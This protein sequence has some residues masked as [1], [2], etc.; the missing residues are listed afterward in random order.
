MKKIILCI[1]GLLLQSG[2]ASEYPWS[3]YPYMRGSLSGFPD[4]TDLFVD[5]LVNPKE[6]DSLYGPV[7][8]WKNK[9]DDSYIQ[10]TNSLSSLSKAISQIISDMPE[11]HRK[12]AIKNAIGNYCRSAK[13]KLLIGE[14][15]KRIIA[16]VAKTNLEK[17]KALAITASDVSER[18]EQRT[19]S[20]SFFIISEQSDIEKHSF[21]GSL[22]PFS[23]RHH[24]VE[25]VD[26]LK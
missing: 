9:R 24:E 26:W 4:K 14:E 1:F 8:V 5:I 7:L 10:I 11:T 23:I 21:K 16:N 18:W 22:N 13:N 15:R 17:S 20:L 6:S 12:V 2:I 25:L 19:W 3:A